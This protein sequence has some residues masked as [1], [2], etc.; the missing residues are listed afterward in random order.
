LFRIYFTGEVVLASAAF[1][2]AL[3]RTLQL[4]PFALGILGDPKCLLWVISSLNDIKPRLLIVATSRARAKARG[5][6]R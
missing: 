1:D 3:Q 5:S 6:V 4:K 2:E